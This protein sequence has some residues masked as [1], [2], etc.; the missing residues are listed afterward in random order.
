MPSDERTFNLEY[1]EGSEKRRE[2]E[3]NQKPHVTEDHGENQPENQGSP[4]PE[5]QWRGNAG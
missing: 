3:E 1:P 5:T 4:V 2:Y